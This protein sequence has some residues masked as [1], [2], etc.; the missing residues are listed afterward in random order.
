MK[1]LTR[2][3]QTNMEIKT[4]SVGHN[5]LDDDGVQYFAAAMKKQNACRL[6]HLNLR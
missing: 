3:L 2:G 5:R 6:E 4:L 1:H